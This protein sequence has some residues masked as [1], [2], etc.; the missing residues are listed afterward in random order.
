L[1]QGKETSSQACY[2]K[3][4]DPPGLLTMFDNGTN[5]MLVMLSTGFSHFL[6]D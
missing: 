3:V 5:T 6:A 4:G 2:L 1:R